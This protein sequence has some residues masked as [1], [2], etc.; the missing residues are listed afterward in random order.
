ML[1][2]WLVVGHV[3]DANPAHPVRGPKY[4]QR[5]ARRRCS[6]ARRRARS[7]PRLIPTPSKACEVH[8]WLG[9]AYHCSFFWFIA[10]S[11]SGLNSGAA[12]FVDAALVLPHKSPPFKPSPM[13]ITFTPESGIQDRGEEPFPGVKMA[14]CLAN[15]G[16][17]HHGGPE[18]GGVALPRF[19]SSSSYSRS[20]TFVAPGRGADSTMFVPK[21]S[22][23]ALCPLTER[24]N[25]VLVGIDHQ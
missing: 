6:T 3:L 18:L 21:T 15:R 13:S 8:S 16:F 23:V 10:T 12:A 2:D 14:T 4:S 1:L 5:K 19:S 24:P 22:I 11:G 25:E 9:V 7:L 20:S 17:G